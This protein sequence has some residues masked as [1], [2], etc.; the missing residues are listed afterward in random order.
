M[1]LHTIALSVLLLVLCD[2]TAAAQDASNTQLRTCTL[3]SCGPDSFAIFVRVADGNSPTTLPDVSVEMDEQVVR[4]VG[5]FPDPKEP[6]GT[7]CGEHSN[8]RMSIQPAFDCE[9]G[10]KCVPAGK[11]NVRIL[12]M[13]TPKKVRVTMLGDS[14]D[15]ATFEPKYEDHFPNGPNCPPPCRLARAVWIVSKVWNRPAGRS[16]SHDQKGAIP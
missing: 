10:G 7:R 3:L 1:R 14:S 15:H 6:F 12:V 9:P 11:D 8:V 5:L 2:E 16:Y 13:G 4:C